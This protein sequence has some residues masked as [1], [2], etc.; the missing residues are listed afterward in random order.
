MEKSTL[1]LCNL[2]GKM[3]LGTYSHLY[4]NEDVEV[5]KRLDQII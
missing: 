1:F 3:A 5:V 4:P 2:N